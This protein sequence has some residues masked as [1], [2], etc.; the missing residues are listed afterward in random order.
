MPGGVQGGGQQE[1]DLGDL[2]GAGTPLGV[3]HGTAAE[4]MRVHD[5]V[6]VRGL[7][8]NG[9]EAGDERIGRPVEQAGR[10]TVMLTQRQP[11][12]I[13]RPGHRDVQPGLAL[14]ILE[15]LPF[16]A[17]VELGAPAGAGL[18]LEGFRRAAAEH[19]S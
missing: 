4:R 3:D 2:E 13:R 14:E 8:G 9:E 18:A 15:Q 19:P 12:P 17:R 1:A 11:V 7:A 16:V 5:G 6:L 10:E